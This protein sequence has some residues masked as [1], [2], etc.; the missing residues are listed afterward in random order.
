VSCDSSAVRLPKR[1][2][3]QTG[4]GCFEL[5]CGARGAA[6]APLTVTVQTALLGR[7]ASSAPLA[8]FAAVNTSAN[9]ATFLFNFLVDGASTR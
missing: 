6:A 1:Y 5:P 2:R 9:L 4:P 3:S 8:A 7:E